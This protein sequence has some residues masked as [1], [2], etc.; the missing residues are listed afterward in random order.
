MVAAP[1]FARRRNASTTRYHIG[2]SDLAPALE[3]PDQRHL[4]GILEVAADRDAACDP[5]DRADRVREP[6]G[7]VHRGGLALERRVRRDDNLLERHSPRLRL[8]G[9]R[10]ELADAEAVGADPVDRR[11]RAVEDVVQA[12]ELA[13]PLEGEHVERL[14]DDTEPGLVPA[15]GGA[16]AAH[17]RGAD[18]EAALAAHDPV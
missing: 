7:E 9:A 5:G 2:R 18:V 1:T 12:L 6:L 14:L 3:G 4:V 15:R 11:D 10:Q 16:D 13:G 8:V 17:R